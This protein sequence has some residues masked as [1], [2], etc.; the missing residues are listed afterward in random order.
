MYKIEKI[1]DELYC[2]NDES[3]CT[4]YVLIGSK[5]A[6]VIDTGIKKNESMLELI[7]LITSLDLIVI[8]THGHYDHTG[9]ISEFSKYYLHEADYECVLNRQPENIKYLKNAHSLKHQDKFDIGDNIIEVVH[10]PG[11]TKGSVVIIDKKHKI[12]FTGDQFGSGCG[13]W[14]QVSE[15]LPLSI[16]IKSIEEFKKH[17]EDNYDIDFYDWKYYGGHLGQEHTGKLGFNPLNSEMVD[18]LKILS[19]LLLEG[20]LQ[21]EETDATEFNGEKSYYVCYKNAEMIIR[22]SLIK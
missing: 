21:L 4:V 6:M 15:G 8:L 14:M 16:Y 19:Q 22:K 7:R 11:H 1:N 13:V 2:I 5:K 10:T 12:L 20:K 3:M 18:N 17:L 9:Y